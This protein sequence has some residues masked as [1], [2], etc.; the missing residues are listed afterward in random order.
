MVHYETILIEGQ[1]YEHVWSDANLQLCRGNQCWDEVYN[2][3]NTGRTYTEGEPIQDEPA[4]LEEV[5]EILLG[6]T[7][8]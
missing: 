5:V 6:G 7:D 4:T 2:P 3:I 8:D 1:E